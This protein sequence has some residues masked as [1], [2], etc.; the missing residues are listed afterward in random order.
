MLVTILHNW[1]DSD[2]ELVADRTGGR[3]GWS[4]P[5]ADEFSSW[6]FEPSRKH[7]DISPSIKESEAHHI[8][9]A[10]LL[11]HELT[12]FFVARPSAEHVGENGMEL[13]PWDALPKTRFNEERSLRDGAGGPS[14]TGRRCDQR[15]RRI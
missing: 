15:E 4:S 13:K 10:G 11:A 3:L 7:I 1:S 12:P 5:I 6:Y 9:D 2:F 14:A 8:A